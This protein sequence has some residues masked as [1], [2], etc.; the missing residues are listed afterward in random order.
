MGFF[1]WLRSRSLPLYLSHVP[2]T[3]IGRPRSLLAKP[4]RDSERSAAIKRAAAADVARLEQDDK[5][6]RSDSP[7]NEDGF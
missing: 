6:F 7:G 5:Y 3:G 2:S 1:S 4:G